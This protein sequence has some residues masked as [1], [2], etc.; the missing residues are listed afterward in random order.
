[1]NAPFIQEDQQRAKEVLYDFVK[2]AIN[3]VIEK[4]G[5]KYLLQ[6]YV[7][8]A[9]LKQITVDIEYTPMKCNKVLVD[10]PPR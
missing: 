10:R 6:P 7:I 8:E 9:I 2:D 1:M 4:E 5:R 3:D